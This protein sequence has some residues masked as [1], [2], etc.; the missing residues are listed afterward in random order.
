MRF[1]RSKQLRSSFNQIDVA[2]RNYNLKDLD[3][4]CTSSGRHK[5]VRILHVYKNPRTLKLR[6]HD[7]AHC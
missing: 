6:E 4:G 1:V 3:V 7:D 5:I 2:A